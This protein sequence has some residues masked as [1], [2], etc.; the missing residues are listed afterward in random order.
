MLLD[1]VD[2]LLNRR[3]A[4]CSNPNPNSS[5]RMKRIQFAIS[6]AVAALACQS[7]QATTLL[8][9]Q[10]VNYADGLLGSTDTGGGTTVPGWRNSKTPITVTNGS[11]SLDGTTL[12]LVLPAGDKVF[13][14]NSNMF[15]VNPGYYDGCYNIFCP[16]NTFQQSSPTNLYYSFLFRFNTATEVS[17]DGQPFSGVSRWNGG[18]ASS[19]G[20]TFHWQLIARRV[21][22]DIQLGIT[23]NYYLAGSVTN[24]ATTSLAAGETFFVVVRQQI[25]T[26]AGNDVYDL[27][28]NPPANSFGVDEASIPPSSATVSAGTEDASSSGPGRFWII[29]SGGSGNLDEL[30]IATTWAEA[31]PPLG[32]C[33]TAGVDASPTDWTQVEGIGTTLAVVASGTSPSYQ[34]QISGP[35]SSTWTNISGAVFPTYT[36]PNLWLPDDNDTKYRAIVNVACNGTSAT[37]SVA[38]VTLTSPVATPNGIVMDDTFLDPAE[39]ADFRD[40]MPISITNS[41]WYTQWSDLLTAY[42]QNGNMLGTPASGSSS[43]WLGYFTADT[44]Q[45]VHLAVGRAIKVTLPFTPNSFGSH[46]NNAALRFGLFD[47]ADGGTRVVADGNTVTGSSGNG[48]NVRGYMVSVDFGPAFTANS[49]LSL[50]VRNG[51]GDSS[52]MG[53]TGDYVSMGSGPAGGGYSNAPAFQ[54]GTEYTLVFTVARTSQNAAQVTAAISGG[55]TNWSY[56]ATET[57]LAYHR[58]DAFAIRPNSIETSAD[59]FTFS[60]FIIEVTNGPVALVSVAPFSITSVQ[61]LSPTAVKLT[62]ASENGASYHILSS[63]SLAAPTWTTNATVPAT[64]SS[65]SYTNTPTSGTERYYRVVGLPRNP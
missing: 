41:V 38:T 7:V 39:I 22:S 64:G 43:L 6:V 12:G 56:S 25:L 37:S 48:R 35:G 65:T 24:Y 44:N 42:Q 57:N 58:F 17:T 53:T 5:N 23:K 45:P 2:V 14:S 49:P 52:L 33:N 63:P 40:N 36:T 27:Y 8:T 46:T 51:L 15:G 47:Y 29:A 34:W 60:Q 31:T 13:I 30:R 4:C 1:A 50:L 10:F 11:G 54:A 16:Q 62:W 59:S 9:E 3:A 26:G 28:V 20:Q 21:G 55:G 32:Q 19:S 18:I 61:T